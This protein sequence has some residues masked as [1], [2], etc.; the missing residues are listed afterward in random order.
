[1]VGLPAATI[2]PSHR[3]VGDVGDLDT[4]DMASPLS[5]QDHT[6]RFPAVK[7]QLL[8]APLTTSYSNEKNSLRPP[9]QSP[10]SLFHRTDSHLQPPPLPNLPVLPILPNNVRSAHAQKGSP[11]TSPRSAVNAMS[12]RC[13]LSSYDCVWFVSRC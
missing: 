8:D 3:D 12:H 11:T 2:D 1:M 13:H 5:D 9:I 4:P 10:Q 7:K 6:P